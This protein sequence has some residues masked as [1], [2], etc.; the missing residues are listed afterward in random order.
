MMGARHR[1]RRRPLAC[2]AL[3]ATLHT[4][5]V[6]VCFYGD[7]ASNRARCSSYNLAKIW[8]LPMVFVAGTMA[9]PDRRR[10]LVGWRQPDSAT[11]RFG[12]PSREVD[13]TDFF[14]VYEASGEAIERARS[15]GG[16][17]LLH[18]R[19]NRFYG[20]FEGDAMTYRHPDEV[21]HV[22]ANLDPIAMFRQRITEASLISASDL[23][24]IDRELAAD[25]ARCVREAKAAPL[26][27]A[28]D[29]MT[30]LRLVLRA[31]K[32]RRRAIARP[33]TV[34]RRWSDRAS[35]S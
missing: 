4:G 17:S 28:A 35:S 21:P 14:D 23:D 6:S 3:T 5:G 20:H 11:Q 34:C 24:A 16:P 18:V 19:L 29:L 26:P 7:G 27:T 12:I 1:R 10:E 13:G 25:I 8:N 15:G 22:R 30:D 32:C 2:G 9:M 31:G 33:S